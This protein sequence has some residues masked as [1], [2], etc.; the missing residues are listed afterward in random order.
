MPGRHVNH[1]SKRTR[2]PRKGLT[3]RL[4][5]LIFLLAA[6]GALSIFSAN[7]YLAMQSLH[8][9][10]DSLEE[11]LE[12]VE[13]E[14]I[15]L[16]EQ[17]DQIHEEKEKLREENEILREENK[18]MRSETIIEHGNRETNKVA[19]TI[20]D[21]AD[22][23]LT[24]RALD[25]LREHNLQATLFPKGNNVEQNPEVWQ[26]AVEE[27][28]ELG[29]HTY[30]HPFITNIST[31]RVR[32]EISGWQESVDKAVDS[33]YRTL[34]FRPPY[35]DGF[36]SGQSHHTGRLQEI[37]AEKGMF[38]VLWD[39]ELI[40]AL[41]NQAYTPAR[42][43]EHVLANAKGGS[44]VLLHFNE[45]DIDALPDIIS[46]LRDRGLEPCSLSELLLD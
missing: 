29:N 41:R 13:Q 35:G 7:L 6:V 8:R 24:H 34:F 17:Y 2:Q 43:T 30:S 10:L 26:R 5:I 46:G 9:N 20:D 21:G 44:I 33:S 15:K 31:D 40:Y 25:Y 18:M 23:A 19:I 42:V 4:A 3:A 32:E 12:Q 37:I 16:E 14:N 1:Y 39:V 11:K 36:L 27:G 28:H 22:A 38:T 45:A